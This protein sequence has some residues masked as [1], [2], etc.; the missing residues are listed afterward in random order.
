MRQP[1]AEIAGRETALDRLLETEARLEARL[2]AAR[3]E[4]DA[5]VAAAEATVKDDHAALDAE[6]EA[7]RVA[8]TLRLAS[9]VS[10]R[11][12]ALQAG[13]DAALDR[14][15]R[16]G[17]EQLE[18]MVAWLAAEVVADLGSGVQR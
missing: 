2:E 16:V 5:R 17:R 8:S 13:R 10:E 14:L 7:A 9:G 15:D 11:V 6:L 3:R 4:G 18:Q 1:I 12:R